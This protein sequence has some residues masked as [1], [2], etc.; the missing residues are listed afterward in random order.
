MEQGKKRT[1]TNKS[2]HL[3]NLT[4]TGGKIPPQAIDLEESILGAII[5]VPGALDRLVNILEEDS[6]YREENRLIYRAALT[7]YKLGTPVDIMTVYNQLKKTEESDLVGGLEYIKTIVGKLSNSSNIEF[8]ARILVEKSISRKLILSGMTTQ[9]RGFD[10][11]ID[12][13]TALEQSQKELEEISAGVFR[14]SMTHTSKSWEKTAAELRQPLPPGIKTGLSDFDDKAGRLEPGDLSILAAR[15]GMGKTALALEILKFVAQD[16]K[17]VAFFSQEMARAQLSQRQISRETGIPLYRIRNRQLTDQELDYID[18]VGGA[19]K[20]T[21]LFIDY[22]SQLAP[23]ELRAKA[24]TVKAKNG[25]RLDL[26][27]V[28][29][30]QIMRGDGERYSSR[31]QEISS[32]ARSL[33]SIAKDINV[34]VLA[35]CQLSRE[36]EKRN[37][38]EPRLSDLRESGSIEQEADNVYFIYR[39]EYYSDNPDETLEIGATGVSVPMRGHVTLIGAK[40]RQGEPFRAYLRADLSQMKFFN[41]PP[42]YGRSFIRYE[43]E[44]FP[45]L[46]K[47]YVDNSI[48]DFA[49]F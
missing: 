32:I 10:E 42:G 39:P 34:H 12:G 21:G 41:G 38:P 35:L 19:L 47:D 17:V 14:Q 45:E 48:K 31:E 5:F 26:I 18:R 24:S 46:F 3:S 2:T 4:E 15:P 8:H 49:V 44:N 28:D 43:A 1:N 16:D 25:G 13:L 37:N 30:L 23:S 7:L 29:Y 11:T 22:T 6:F 20:N 36:T 9:A 40:Y 33:K 27:V